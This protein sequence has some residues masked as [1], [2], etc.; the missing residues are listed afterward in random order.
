MNTDENYRTFVI[1][2]T[3]INIDKGNGANDE[4]GK[5]RLWSRLYSAE[6]GHKKGKY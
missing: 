5:I 1:V 3:F 4:F 2:F 6:S